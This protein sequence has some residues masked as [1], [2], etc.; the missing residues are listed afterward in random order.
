MSDFKEYTTVSTGV[1]C[2]TPVVNTI[3]NRRSWLKFD[4]DVQKVLLIL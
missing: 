3:V 1:A 4:H 2:A